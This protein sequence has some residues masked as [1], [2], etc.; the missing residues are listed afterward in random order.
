MKLKLIT[1]AIALTAWTTAANAVYIETNEANGEKSL[2]T[3]LND[4]TVDGDSSVNVQTDQ[5]TPSSLWKNT[6]SGTTQSR[7][8]ASIAGNTTDGLTSVGIYDPNDPFNLNKRYTL[9]DTATDSVGTG[10]VFGVADDGKVYDGE[11]AEDFTGIQFGGDTFGFF[12]TIAGQGGYT[13]YSQNALNP[14]DEQQMVA[15]QGKGDDVDLGSV[16]GSTNWKDGWILAWEDQSYASSDM[17]FNDFVLFLESA[18][19]VPEPGTL[20]LLG[21]GLAGLGAARRRQKA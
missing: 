8:V 1:V 18:V 15:F 7:Y 14:N 19:P 2:Q 20:A 5:A 16:F 9:F 6:E 3:I 13:L 17:D 11:N 4:I 21:L 12:L 10:Q